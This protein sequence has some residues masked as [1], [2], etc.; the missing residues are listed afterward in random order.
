[1]KISHLMIT[2]LLQ[3]A[4]GRLDDDEMEIL[5]AQL[6]DRPELNE[7]L[8]IIRSIVQ[9]DQDD[10]YADLRPATR[11][12]FKKILSDVH[13]AAKSSC[14]NLAANTFDSKLLP[15]MSGVRP[16]IVNSRQMCFSFGTSRVEMSFYPI[17]STS[18]NII[19]QL[20][21]TGVENPLTIIFR[22]GKKKYESITNEYGIFQLDRVTSGKC[23]LSVD[24]QDE[25]LI[26]AEI[27]L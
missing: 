7:A 15:Q 1:M 17:T 20:S 27:D 25:I 18:Y 21:G 13:R 6:C 2:K 19:G 5:E 26:T 9:D 22:S 14:K 12:I 8:S 16:A 3:Y 4:S 24:H 10:I 11:D 23:T